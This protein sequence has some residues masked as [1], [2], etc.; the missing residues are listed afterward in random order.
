MENKN[1]EKVHG[2]TFTLHNHCHNGDILISAEDV[3]V[4]TRSFVFF[5]LIAPLIKT[6][7]EQKY[8]FL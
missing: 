2:T 6:F 3:F 1:P 8:I 7:R 4:E 5:I